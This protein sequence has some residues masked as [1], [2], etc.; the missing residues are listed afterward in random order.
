MT[1][2]R[3]AVS[4]FKALM[5]GEKGGLF[6]ESSRLEGGQGASS[7][8]TPLLLAWR[9]MLG[10]WMCCD[11][12]SFGF[13]REAC[14]VLQS[15]FCCHRGESREGPVPGWRD[16]V[17]LAKAAAPTREEFPGICGGKSGRKTSSLQ[18]KGVRIRSMTCLSIEMWHFC[19]DKC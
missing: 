15:G 7:R 12:L 3:W 1:G 8:E 16:G 9:F 10:F 4:A 13:R 2:S 18:S 11:A 19:L 14:S 5:W 6:P 17:R